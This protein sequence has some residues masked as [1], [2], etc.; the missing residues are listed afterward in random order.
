MLFNG[1]IFFLFHNQ[2]TIP[3][4]PQT[5]E[6]SSFLDFLEALELC[7]ASE[8]FLAFALL[9]ILLVKIVNDRKELQPSKPTN[10]GGR[11]SVR[12]KIDSHSRQFSINALFES[13]IWFT[14]TIN[15]LLNFPLMFDT[16]PAFNCW[17]HNNQH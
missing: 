13:K 7:S 11:G 12:T 3:F 6:T 2:W 10:F 1:F 17:C 9:D 4:P 8:A 5:L 14:T 15:M 16:F